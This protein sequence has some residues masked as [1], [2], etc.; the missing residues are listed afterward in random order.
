VSVVQLVGRGDLAHVACTSFFVSVLT[1]I[2]LGKPYIIRKISFCSF[3]WFSSFL[4][5]VSFSRRYFI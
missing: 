1:I 3:R 2:Y 5:L 4:L